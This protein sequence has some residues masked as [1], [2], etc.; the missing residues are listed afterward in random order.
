MFKQMFFIELFLSRLQWEQAILGVI[1]TFQ[2]VL[3]A[4]FYSG[5]LQV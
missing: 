5:G 1:L 4:F 2:F 3:E